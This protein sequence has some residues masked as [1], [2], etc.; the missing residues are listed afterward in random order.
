MQ[1]LRHHDA[2]IVS[3]LYFLKQWPHWPVALKTPSVNLAN[4]NVDYV[5]DDAVVMADTL[6]GEALVGMGCTLIPMS[7]FEAFERPWFDYTQ[8]EHGVWTV[9]EDVSF[10][11]KAAA[12]G[13]P[14]SVDPTVKCGHVGSDAVS[15]PWFLRSQVEMHALAERQARQAEAVA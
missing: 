3:G 15:E 2:G 1:M 14:I 7:V 11:Q 5:Y 9:T 13:V 8:N 4:G 12:V 10:C 6:Q